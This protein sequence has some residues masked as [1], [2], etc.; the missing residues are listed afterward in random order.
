MGLTYFLNDLKW[1]Q[2]LQLLLV[3]LYYYCYYY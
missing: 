1:L 3:L 2:S